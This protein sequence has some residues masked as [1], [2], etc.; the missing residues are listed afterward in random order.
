ML[1]GWELYQ[2]LPCCSLPVQRGVI[3]SSYTSHLSHVLQNLFHL[4]RDLLLKFSISSPALLLSSSLM[5]YFHESCK[6]AV[7]S[8]ILE[9]KQNKSKR[10]K[11]RSKFNI[12]SH[13]VLLHICPCPSQQK[14]SKMSIG[15]WVFLETHSK[16]GKIGK[17]A[18]QILNSH[19]NDLPVLWLHVSFTQIKGEI[20]WLFIWWR[21]TVSLIV[22]TFC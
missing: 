10:K 4:F 6:H 19:C 20:W 17:R 15:W 9:R 11:Y 7:R 5:D 16:S 13:Q 3:P 18:P 21:R 1:R 12:P 8:L 2:S 14:F 22:H